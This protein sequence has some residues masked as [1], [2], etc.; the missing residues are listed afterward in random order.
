MV[1]QRLA[2]HVHRGTRAIERMVEFAPSTGGLALWVRHHDLAEETTGAPVRTD[3]NALYYGAGFD[4][5][6]LAEQAGLVA[7]E[8]LHIALRHPQRFL[9]LQQLLGD[10][11]LQ[12]FNICAD[13]IVNSTLAHLSWLKVPKSAV[14]LD[15]L[16]SGALKLNQSVEK[17]LLEW[18]VE[19]LYRAIDDR[20]AGSAG[21]GRQQQ[22]R[23]GGG[24]G[25]SHP[26]SGRAQAREDGPRSAQVRALGADHV[27]DLCP[28]PDSLGAPE[29]EAD[30]VRAW[31]ERVLR[32][33][34]SDGMHS[35]MRTLIA[36]LA[37]VRTPWE[38]VLRTHMARGLAPKLDIS[39]SRPARSY[40]AN[41]GR[42][43]PHRRL[44]WTPG[45]RCAKAVPRLAL[46]VDVSGSI[47]GKLL[48]RFA[49]EIEAITR[50]LEAGLVLI[51]GD[52]R[53][54]RVER[55][56]PGLPA[57]GKIEFNGGGGTDFT[58]L[59]EEAG[60]HNPDLTVILTD[61]DGP[62]RCRPRC[63]VIWAVP[64]EHAGRAHPFGRKLALT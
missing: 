21:S 45:L 25:T 24:A 4:R 56:E 10:V 14:L 52:D 37:R 47:S 49:G 16:L 54:R 17:S 51:V 42:A 39:W 27:L 63:P 33:H 58:P 20:Q 30:E 36:D 44:P 12:L 35:M 29:A 7:H 8:V 32:A 41:Q 15:G 53:V 57:L 9:Q 40:I 26:N 11:D 59:L 1:E 60:R 13:A 18:D 19:R 46:I 3:G 5:V 23:I 34:A 38:Q 31:S 43:G 22:R 2:M 48:E 61:L 55:F 6:P 28:H 64:E 50:R 62:A